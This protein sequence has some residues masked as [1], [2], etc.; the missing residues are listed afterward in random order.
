MLLKP[1]SL[2]HKTIVIFGEVLAD[3][4]PDVTLL[5]GAPFNVARHLQALG[6]HPLFITRTGND[7]LREELITY[8]HAWDMDISGLQLDTSHSTGKVIVHIQHGG[9]RFEILPEQAYDFIDPAAIK[10]S[11]AGRQPDLIYF[12][13]LAQRAPKSRQALDTL[14][15]ETTVPRLV[16]IN[17]R[18]PW[19]DKASVEYSLHHTNILKLNAEE[20]ETISQVLGIS[21]TTP[22]AQASTLI[23]QYHLQHI[24]TTTGD[25]GAWVLDENGVTTQVSGYQQSAALQDTVGAGDG[26]SAVYIIGYLAGWPVETTLE[27]ANKF[28]AAICTIKGA[29]PDDSSF[30]APFIREWEL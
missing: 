25:S 7:P 16:D 23:N 17:L 4:F 15:T 27:R 28:A 6:L 8:M 5:G 18:S 3:V 2:K 24:I 9:H 19:Y 22:E 1:T 12:G 13:S 14:L 10:N 26:F 30:Y 20:L 29:A 21:Q 11:L